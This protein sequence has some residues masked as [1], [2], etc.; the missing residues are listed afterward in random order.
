MAFPKGDVASKVGR[1]KGGY[2][3]EGGIARQEG[4]KKGK[5]RL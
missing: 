5:F 3:V 2:R 4:K 1:I